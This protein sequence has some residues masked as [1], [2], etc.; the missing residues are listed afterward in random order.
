[1]HLIC[2]PFC[3]NRDETEFRF[4]VEAGKRRGSVSSSPDEWA[5][6]LYFQNNVKGDTREVWM[7]LTCGELFILS[8]NSVTHS[9]HG[10]EPVRKAAEA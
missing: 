9:I 5:K 3:G 1:M 7:H 6:Y 8:R 10:S 4:A 2:C